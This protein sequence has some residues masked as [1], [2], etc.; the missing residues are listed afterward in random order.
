[1]DQTPKKLVYLYLML[2]GGLLSIIAEFIPWALNLSPFKMIQLGLDPLIYLLPLFSG[3]I[4]I[5]ASLLLSYSKSNIKYILYILL[6][7]GLQLT[8]LFISEVYTIHRQY[9]WN[10]F[11]IYLIILST[12]LTFFG[13]L[14]KLSSPI[15]SNEDID[16]FSEK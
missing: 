8:F 3:I 12:L 14:M 7:F 9:L 13:I 4:I 2:S 5:L 11:G 10:Y 15:K 16:S 1:M 6:F